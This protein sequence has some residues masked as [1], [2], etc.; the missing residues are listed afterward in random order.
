MF[1]TLLDSKQRKFT[2]LFYW[3]LLVFTIVVS[4]FVYKWI[5]PIQKQTT[6]ELIKY[7]SK[8]I[9]KLEDLQ[10]GDNVIF[11]NQNLCV[12]SIE[13]LNLQKSTKDDPPVVTVYFRKIGDCL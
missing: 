7:V 8:D 4:V 9:V 2:I 1:N 11:M 10:L 13:T 3:C 12:S 5:N 6:T